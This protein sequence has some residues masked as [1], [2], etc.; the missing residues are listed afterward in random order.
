MDSVQLRNHFPYLGSESSAYPISINLITTI[1]LIIRNKSLFHS[2]QPRNHHGSSPTLHQSFRSSS[3]CL[4]TYYNPMF[5]A[6]HTQSIVITNPIPPF[7]NLLL[8]LSQSTM[9]QL[10]NNK[11]LSGTR[12]QPS[13]PVREYLAIVF[14]HLSIVC[15]LS[16]VIVPSLGFISSRVVLKTIT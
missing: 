14:P 4:V 10:P 12:T 11:I 15:L 6:L 2:S 8:N 9:H 3:T 13:Q 7:Y 16:H 1:I 5:N